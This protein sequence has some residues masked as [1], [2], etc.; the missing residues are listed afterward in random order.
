MSD[1]DTATA[2]KLPPEVQ[3]ELDKIVTTTKRGFDIQARMKNRGLRKA[4]ITL[5]LD[6]EKGA[7]L[8]WAED[9][10]DPTLGT[11]I[12]REREG[13]TGELDAAREELEGLPKTG[14][15]REELEARIKGLEARCE[16][17][18]AELIHS[19]IVVKMRAVPPVIEEDCHRLARQT[20]GITEK[21]VPDD[22]YKEYLKAKTAH[23]MSKMFQ[24]VTDNETGEVN[25]E[26]TYEDA[27][28]IIGWLPPG[29]F[30]RL[31]LAMGKVQFTD[32]I[33]RAIEGQED[34]S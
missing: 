9:R 17:L 13:V 23:M 1:T 28:V 6:D 32:G 14:K 27:F 12:G 7:E 16:E 20:L 15:K 29:Q 10:F 33:S 22:R 21:G 2:E 25:E 11:K 3:E 26:V 19:A 5:F 30:E 8:G 24:S 34:F 4:T 31:D 18:L